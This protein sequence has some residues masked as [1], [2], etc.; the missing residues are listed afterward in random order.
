MSSFPKPPEPKKFLIGWSFNYG[1]IEEYW[2]DKRYVHASDSKRAISLYV[3]SEVSP[4][5]TNPLTTLHCK[6]MKND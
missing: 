5:R 4:I 2:V 6:E 3:N 1:T